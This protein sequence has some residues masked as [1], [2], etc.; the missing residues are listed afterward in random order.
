MKKRIR[1]QLNRSGTQECQI[2]KEK[3]IL[4]EHHIRGRDI[5][6]A[7][8]PSNCCNICPNC[9]NA[10][11]HGLIII[12]GYFQTSNGWELLWHKSNEES[13]SGENA[14]SYLISSN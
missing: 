5:P 8:K 1:K 14:S 13:F 9:H 11:H 2:C 7:N 10:V 4:V 3:N 6:N 12:E